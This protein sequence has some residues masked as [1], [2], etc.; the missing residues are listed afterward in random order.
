MI[1]KMDSTTR[2]PRRPAPRVEVAS[3]QLSGRWISPILIANILDEAGSVDNNGNVQPAISEDQ[4]AQ[5][6]TH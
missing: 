5:N 2:R 6:E 3:F 4:S 1:Y